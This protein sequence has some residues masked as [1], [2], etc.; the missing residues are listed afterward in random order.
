MSAPNLTARAPAWIRSWPA[1]V[2]ALL[3]LA[4]LIGWTGGT[5]LPL[6]AH[7]AFVVQTAQEM[8]DRGD[9]IVPYFNG[10]PRLTKPPLSYWLTGLAGWLSGALDHL[11]PWHGRLPPLLAGIGMVGLALV[12]GVRLYDRRTALMAGLILGTSLGFFLYTHSARPELLYSFWCTA[13]L[14]AFVL[15]WQAPDGDYRQRMAAY[16]MWG[17]FALATLTKGP[18]LPAM[19]LLGCGLFLLLQ[20]L[21]WRRALRILRPLAGTAILLVITVPWWWAVHSRLGGEG[22][23]S[24]QLA[25]T[26]L[27]PDWSGWLSPYYLY[28]P[29]QMV[30]PWLLL[31]PGALLLAWRCR[32][33]DHVQLLALNILIPAAILSFGP[34]QRWFYMLP[35]LA[36]LCLL[37]A[38]SAIEPFRPA[39]KRRKPWVRRLVALQV[40]IGLMFGGALVLLS[41]SRTFWGYERYAAV[42]LGQA[43]T[44]QVPPGSVVGLWGDPP[45]ALVYYAG[46]SLPR[47]PD[48]QT[49]ARTLEETPEHRLYL[50]LREKELPTLPPWMRIERLA[51]SP[52]AE[53]GRT[54]LLIRLTPGDPAP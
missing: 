37:L 3:L 38:A 44:N 10:E 4:G 21:P 42:E 49:M 51:R 28:R 7:E 48:F 46:R 2:A 9:W 11:R 18:Q 36:P 12:L 35:T 53:P 33:R 45:D 41:S 13:G 19:L 5:E 23:R 40:A 1:A 14:A 8:H 17:G 27:R 6:D 32:H 26:L 29:L 20:R 30:L 25:G 50:I 31:I 24:S 54:L 39:E 22:L 43:V 52:S 34:Q 15:A 47:Y 16:A